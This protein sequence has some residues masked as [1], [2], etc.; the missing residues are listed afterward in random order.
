MP[1]DITED[2]GRYARVN[3]VL[4]SWVRLVI[5]LYFINLVLQSLFADKITNNPQISELLLAYYP[6]ECKTESLNKNGY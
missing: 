6:I 1:S 2:F 4:I 5:Y 3:C